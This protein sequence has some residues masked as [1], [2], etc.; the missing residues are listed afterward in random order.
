MATRREC[1]GL[2]FLDRC[3]KSVRRRVLVVGAAVYAVMDLGAPRRIGGTSIATQ[4]SSPNQ[5]EDVMSAT[6]RTI[7]AGLAAFFEHALAVV[8]GLVLIV[9]G[10]GLGVTMIMLPVGVVVGLL[11]VLLVVGGLFARINA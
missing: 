6:T 5:K 1:A 11:G 10:L 7:L 4:S 2:P 3:R 8:I 9:I